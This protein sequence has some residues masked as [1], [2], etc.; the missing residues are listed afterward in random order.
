VLIVLTVV[1]RLMLTFNLLPYFI[2]GEDIT[3]IILLLVAVLLF[4]V[5]SSVGKIAQTLAGLQENISVNVRTDGTEA[6][7]LAEQFGDSSGFKL[8][9]GIQ[10]YLTNI[11]NT[12]ELLNKCLV[13]SS[14]LTH[15]GRASIMLHDR[16]RDELFIYKTI[17]W[18]T[19][20][21]HIARKMKSRPGEGIAG[22]V[23][24]DG[25]P[26]IVNKTNDTED[27]DL[28]DKYKS[29]SFV[30]VPIYE[31][32]TIMGVLNLTEKGDMNYSSEEMEL[33]EYITGVVALRLSCSELQ[34]G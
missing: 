13:I 34:N 22:R 24:L 8:L 19:R 32:S 30:S 20:E 6:L 5:S 11:S 3:V 21:L 23:F 17:G 14:K 31:G 4:F 10:R 29:K 1:Y 16:K 18:E 7:A 9:I 26:L 12:E 33:L 27:I 2:S 28:K 25:E 15:S